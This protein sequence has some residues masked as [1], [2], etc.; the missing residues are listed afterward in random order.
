MKAETLAKVRSALFV[1]LALVAVTGSAFVLPVLDGMRAGFKRSFAADVVMP[2]EVILANRA[3][4]IFRA[5]AIS[6]LWMRATRELR[7]FIRIM[8]LPTISMWP[9]MFSWDAKLCE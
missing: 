9:R 3:G 6:T 2:P 7:W 5:F 4:G 1:A 8:P